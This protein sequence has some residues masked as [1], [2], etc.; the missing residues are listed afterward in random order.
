MAEERP[1]LKFVGQRYGATIRFTYRGPAQDLWVGFGIRYDP[2]DYYS[3]PE[4]HWIG[5]YFPVPRSEMLTTI[6][7]DLE[8]IFPPGVLEET[9]LDT[10]KVVG[11]TTPMPA[12]GDQFGFDACLYGKDRDDAVYR[13]PSSVWD[14]SQP[15]ST[16]W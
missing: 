11:P 12:I 3:I 14:I 10:F 2:Y 4:D 1:H 9:D 15:D 5:G 7:V 16:Y 6:E 8:G 13:V